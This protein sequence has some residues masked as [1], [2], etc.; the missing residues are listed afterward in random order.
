MQALI[1]RNVIGDYREPHV[2]RFGF[3]PL[4]L[5]YVDVWDAVETLRDVLESESWRA[6]EF[7]A[8]GAVT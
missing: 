5:R 1:A 8:R 2:L 4:Y 6:P 3:T 7:A